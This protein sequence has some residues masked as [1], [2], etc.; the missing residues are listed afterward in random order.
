MSLIAIDYTAAHEQG[1]GIG[2]YVRELTRAITH[3]DRH[4]DFR[5]FVSG[6][7]AAS[8]PQLK[9]SNV[10]WRA[11]RV[12]PRWLARIWHRAGLPLPIETFV[13]AIDLY[14]ATDFVLPPTLPRTRTLLTV[15]DLSFE[16][17]PSSADPSLLRYLKSAVP[18]SVRRADHILADS[19]AT[20]DDLML[21]YDTPDEKISVLYC[22]VDER[23]A[24]ISDS[25]A[26]D[27]VLKGY[28]LLGAEY[29]LSVGTLQPRKNYPR[30][31]RALRLLRDRGIDLHY[32]I[33]G[34]KGWLLDEIDASIA[35]NRMRDRVHLLGFVEDEHLPVLYGS[36]QALVTASLYEGFGLPLLEAMACGTPVITSNLSSLPEVVGDTGIQV[37]P[38]DVAAIEEAIA[39]VVSDSELRADLI[40]RGYQRAKSFTWERSARQLKAVY[41][42]LLES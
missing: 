26:A 27:R 37:D 11:T 6:A 31:I 15:H 20:K 17:V 36:A 30:V 18:K 7:T 38:G 13:G 1:G 19:Q 2:R 16:R 9:M 35:E 10:N 34:G 3:L 22:G 33:V 41:D 40:Q 24:P 5:L 8:L 25:A 23:F 4:A 14:H 29:V 12:S 32:A 39:R 42:W 28:G 21:L